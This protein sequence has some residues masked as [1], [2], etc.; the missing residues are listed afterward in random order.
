MFSFM[1]FVVFFKV[2]LLW[3]FGSVHMKPLFFFRSLGFGL[4]GCDP[5]AYVCVQLFLQ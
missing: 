4:F 1:G 2:G 3:G 5:R